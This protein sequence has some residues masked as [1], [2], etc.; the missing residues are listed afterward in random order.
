MT[1]FEKM[2][3]RRILC[4]LL[5]I[6]AFFSPVWGQDFVSK[7]MEQFPDAEDI[8]CQTISP[9]MMERLVDVQAGQD[10]EDMNSEVTGY[11]L[12]KLKSARIITATQHCEELF[13]EAGQ[14]MEKNKN[15][16]ISLGNDNDATKEEWNSHIYVRRHD[17]VIRELVML[18][19]A[20]E[21]GT[22]TIVDFTGEMDD[23]FIE[24]LSSGK[25]KDN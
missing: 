17:D 19:L 6:G 15:R 23:R 20:P 4:L 14:L 1:V 24:L 16:F 22:F 10:E 5:A 12:S 11:L 18:D 8:Q 13:R 7:F 9:K 3:K 25:F 21:G 2:S